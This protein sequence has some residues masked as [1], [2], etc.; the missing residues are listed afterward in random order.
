MSAEQPIERLSYR[1]NGVVIATG[2]S[3]AEVWRAIHTDVNAAIDY[4]L[5]KYGLA[6]VRTAIGFE[7]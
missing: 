7:R 2:M 3:R 6:A 4:S 5:K 1:V